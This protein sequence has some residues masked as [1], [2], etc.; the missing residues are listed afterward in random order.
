MGK[1]ILHILTYDFP[2]VG[3]DSKFMI[4]EIKLLSEIFDEIKLYPM[5]KS[6]LRVKNLK[7]NI[8]VDHTILNEILSP[9][10]LIVQFFK[11]IFCK[12]LW[13]EIMAI[14]KKNNLKKIK[15]IFVERYIAETIFAIFKKKK[16]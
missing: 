14:S 12:Y 6:N 3:N 8:L 13:W 11:I 10:N 5:K 4:D 7:K 16:L 9:L 1:K 15:I 2:Y